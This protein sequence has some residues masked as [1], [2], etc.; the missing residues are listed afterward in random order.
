[1][2]CSVVRLGMCWPAVRL[3][4]LRVLVVELPRDTQAYRDRITDTYETKRKKLFLL[5]DS[6]SINLCFVLPSQRCV[7]LSVSIKKT[8]ISHPIKVIYY[9]NKSSSLAN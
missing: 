2:C 4:C 5:V 1:M 9:S 7:S 8:L 6:R 3:V